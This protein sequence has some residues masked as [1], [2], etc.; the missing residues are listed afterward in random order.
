MNQVAAIASRL[1]PT[2]GWCAPKIFCRSEPARDGARLIT[3]TLMT[4]LTSCLFT[5]QAS[6]AEPQ[7]K[8]QAHLQPAEGAMVGGLVELQVDVLTDTWFTSAATLPALKLDGALVTPPDGQAQHLNQTIDGQSFSGLRYSYLI[9]PNVAKR[10]DIPALTVSATPGQATTPLSAQSQPL[11]FSAAQPPGFNPGETPLVASDLRLSQSVINA[12]TP[13]KVGDSITRQLTLQADGVLAMV[14]PAPSMADIAGLSRYPQ[15]PQ[16]TALDD[17]RGS[18]LGGQRIDAE[19]YRIDKAGAY[20]LPAIAVKWWDVKSRQTRSAQVPAVTFEAVADTR[21]K[22]V[23]AISDDLR[24]LGRNTLHVST[25][26]LLWLTLLAVCIGAGFWLRPHLL[27][28][29][30]Q[31]QARRHARQ[32]AWER[33]PDFAWQQIGPQLQAR[34]A[35]LSALYLWLRRS[36]LGLQLVNAGPRLQGLLR[37][38]YGRD[39]HPEQTLVQLRQSLTT[40][41]SQAAQQQRKPAPA[42]RPLN[43]VQE[44]EFP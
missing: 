25:Q 17:G 13:L 28:A 27:R 24:Q 14:L 11:H 41:H 6:A 7:L 34:P 26:W 20:T 35:Q 36:R 22:P 44:R 21:Y 31:W 2:G 38:L 10:Y 43:P 5:I 4:L 39:P 19:T 12:T 37:G 18:V 15:T 3:T 40:L 23:F 16:I 8:I 33:S 42:L 9:T 1:T 29:H 32:L 30:R